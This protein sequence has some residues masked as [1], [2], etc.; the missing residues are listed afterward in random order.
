[1]NAST[2]ACLL[3]Y[4]ICSQENQ[5][6]PE[7]VR[8]APPIVQ[9]SFKT[10]EKSVLENASLTPA[11]RSPA[12]LESRAEIWLLLGNPD[13]ALKDYLSAYSILLQSSSPPAEKLRF[14]TKLS[15]F[16]AQY[17]KNPIPQHVSHSWDYFYQGKKA[18]RDRQYPEAT[19]FFQNAISLSPAEPMF[20]Y[21]MALAFYQT[22][23]REGGQREA[24]MGAFLERNRDIPNR[25]RFL[26]E[27]E[28][29][30]GPARVW[31]CEILRTKPVVF[32]K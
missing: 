26:E 30:Q 24:L 6:L 4:A 3:N 15:A 27:L 28:P 31:L 23:N 17:H 32:E 14:L 19:D 5:P 10:I 25:E 13:A 29:F 11:K 7:L 12:P 1:M 16:L 22:G 8:L 9:E 2:L 21:F 20:H 18:L